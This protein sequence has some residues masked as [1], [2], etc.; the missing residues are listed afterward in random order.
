MSLALRPLLNVFW[1][2][3]FVVAVPRID[4][5]FPLKNHVEVTMATLLLSMVEV[6]AIKPADCTIP[7]PNPLSQIS[8]L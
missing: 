4:P 2:T 3:A 7:F 5:I 1:I 6:S 8:V